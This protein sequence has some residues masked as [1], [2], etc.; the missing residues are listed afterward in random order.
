MNYAEW[1]HVFVICAYKQ[2]VYLQQ[3]IDSLNSQSVKTK[4]IMTTSTPNAF[5]D[6]IAAENHIPLYCNTVTEGRS[7]I[8]GDWNYAIRMARK[9][10]GAKLVTIA[11]QDD[12]YKPQ[13]AE[14]IIRFADRAGHPLLLFTDY[15]ETREEAAGTTEVASN[16][17]LRVKRLMLRPL[18]KRSRWKSVF[19]RRRILSF[20]SAI[21]CPSVTYAVQNLPDEIFTSGF[22]SDLDWEAWEK[23]S[24]LQ[25]DYVY[26]PEILMSHRIHPESATSEIIADHDRSR[27][28]LAMYE[29]FWPTWIARIIEHYYQNS[30]KQNSL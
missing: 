2:S 23:L 14:Q 12:L 29:R 7:D 3:C 28:D 5:V 19:W 17:M 16:R 11:H 4:V 1:D 26:I 9:E 6:R 10:M 27:E 8:A 25:G 15:S 24:R 21:C 30:E 22:R 18:E 13:Y 20:G